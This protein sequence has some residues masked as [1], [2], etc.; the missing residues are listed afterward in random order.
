MLT[1]LS[2]KRKTWRTWEDGLWLLLLRFRA[3]RHH[4]TNRGFGRTPLD[5]LRPAMNRLFTVPYLKAHCLSSFPNN[6]LNLLTGFS[7]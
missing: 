3:T 6:F 5:R 2:S 4:G 7:K 1:R